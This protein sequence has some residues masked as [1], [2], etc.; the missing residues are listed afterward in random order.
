MND[1]SMAGVKVE[2]KFKSKE[3]A[4]SENKKLDKIT[5]TQFSDDGDPIATQQAQIADGKRTMNGELVTW[6]TPVIYGI[7]FTLIPGSNDDRKLRAKLYYHAMRNA[8]A[9][10]LEALVESLVITHYAG[11][12]SDLYE[13]VEFKDG[14]MREGTPVVGSNADGK[15]LPST[16]SFMFKDFVYGTQTESKKTLN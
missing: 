11:D 4:S 1:I 7:T 6:S 5:L 9:P 12:G 14:R 2:I 16:Y 3:D 15:A 8:S 10:R 13:S